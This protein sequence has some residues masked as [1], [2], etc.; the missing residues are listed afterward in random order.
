M[1]SYIFSGLSFHLFT[2]TLSDVLV[3]IGRTVFIYRLFLC[4]ICLYVTINLQPHLLPFLWIYLM[5]PLDFLTEF[6]DRFINPH[7][8]YASFFGLIWA[9]QCFFFSSQCHTIFQSHI[10]FPLHLIVKKWRPVL[11]LPVRVQQQVA[12]SFSHPFVRMDTLWQNV[13]YEKARWKGTRH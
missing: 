9:A 8:L 10:S 5:L 1:S 13:V 6:C 7:I 12:K 4:H 3:N 2:Q 11:F